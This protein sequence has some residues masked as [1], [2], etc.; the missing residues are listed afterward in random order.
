MATILSS[1]FDYNR[2]TM[3]LIADVSDLGVDPFERV[4]GDACDVG[5]RIVSVRTGRSVMFVVHQEVRDAE[6]DILYWILKA[7]RD[8]RQQEPVLQLLTVKVFND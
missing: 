3:Q 6:G 4:Y 5:I 2:D 8:P 7:V 1:K